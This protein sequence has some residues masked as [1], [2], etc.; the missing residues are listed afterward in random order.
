MGKLL[1]ILYLK[2][3][4]DELQTAMIAH[5]IE[6]D[7]FCFAYKKFLRN[8]WICLCVVEVSFRRQCIPIHLITESISTHYQ[9][10]DECL[11]V[12]KALRWLLR[13]LMWTVDSTLMGGY[14]VVGRGLQI[15]GYSKYFGIHKRDYL[16]SLFTICQ[17][18]C[19]PLCIHCHIE[20][21][22]LHKYRNIII[23]SWRIRKLML[24]QNTS[25]WKDAVLYQV[26]VVV[27]YCSRLCECLPV[28]HTFYIHNMCSYYPPPNLDW[29]DGSSSRLKQAWQLLLSWA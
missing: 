6:F 24:Q 19:L 7:N 23:P 27:G 21:L 26:A 25:K 10:L 29:P 14:T 13:W 11:A 16:Q 15:P 2:S 3:G 20:F 5:D 22:H 17:S 9:V 1:Y 4:E 28:T 18:L 12:Y 8:S